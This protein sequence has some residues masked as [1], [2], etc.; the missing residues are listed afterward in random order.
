MRTPF[1]K[2][3]FIVVLIFSSC[4]QR[5]KD[6]KNNA[7]P[8]NNLKQHT[9]ELKNIADSLYNQDN[10]SLAIK[11]LDTLIKIDSTS[12]ENYFMRGYC[13]DQVYKHSELSQ[14]ISDYTRAIN[15]NYK[16]GKTYFNLGLCYAVKNDSMALACFHKSLEADPN[17]FQSA[18]QIEAIERRLE[19]EKKR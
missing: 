9:I 3:Y 19:L 7:L 14:P 8:L 12:G 1:L 15:L 10:Y 5:G 16:K 4:K 6:V 2:N 18:I 13:Y 17:H 11:Y